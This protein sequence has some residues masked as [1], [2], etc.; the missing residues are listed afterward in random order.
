MQTHGLTITID[1]NKYSGDW[2]TAV[3]QNGKVV[4][5]DPSEDRAIVRAAQKLGIKLWNES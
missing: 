3:M 1:V 2:F 5:E 4:C